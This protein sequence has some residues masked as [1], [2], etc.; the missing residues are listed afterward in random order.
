MSNRGRKIDVSLRPF[1]HALR[2]LGFRQ[3]YSQRATKGCPLVQ[4]YRREYPEDEV[5]VHVRLWG[6]G[7]HR[8]TYSHPNLWVTTCERYGHETTQP[9]DFRTVG[10]M[11]NAIEDQRTHWLRVE[12]A[13]EEE[14]V[15]ECRTCPEHIE[16]PMREHVRVRLAKRAHLRV[17]PVSECPGGCGVKGGG[18]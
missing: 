14:Y 1:Q 13:V 7:A 15:R 18:S 5:C 10:Q 3:E 2:R 11:L 6:D 4:E 17:V 16:P 8:V 9:V 12:R